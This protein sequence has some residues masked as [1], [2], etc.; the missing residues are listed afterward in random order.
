MQN[1]VETKNDSVEKGKKN[2][3]IIQRKTDE[4]K[5]FKNTFQS[6]VIGHIYQDRLG[7]ILKMESKS[8]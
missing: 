5:P 8:V 2:N 7:L 6:K 3:V 4:E 1:F